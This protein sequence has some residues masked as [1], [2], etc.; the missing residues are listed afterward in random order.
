MR[1]GIEQVH[2]AV[3]IGAKRPDYARHISCNYRQA[4]A[5]SL[6]V[7]QKRATITVRLSLSPSSPTFLSLPFPSLW[8]GVSINAARLSAVAKEKRQT[9]RQMRNELHFLCACAHTLRTHTKHAHTRSSACHLALAL[10]CH[11]INL[12]F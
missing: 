8:E 5:L 7:K 3:L 11:S 4:M 12:L 10:N 9:A 2:M 1:P 6:V